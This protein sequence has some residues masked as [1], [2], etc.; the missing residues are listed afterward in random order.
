MASG[1]IGLFER[2][3]TNRLPIEQKFGPSVPQ[4]MSANENLASTIGD[5]MRN[6][7]EDRMEHEVLAVLNGWNR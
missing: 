7:F 6:T 1:H 4:M 3:G 5:Q 2:S